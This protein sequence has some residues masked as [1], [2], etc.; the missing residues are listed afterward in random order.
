M[1]PHVRFGVSK[2]IVTRVDYVLYAGNRTGVSE[3]EQVMLANVEKGCTKEYRDDLPSI[4]S[5]AKPTLCKLNFQLT[6]ISGIIVNVYMYIILTTIDSY[7]F[8]DKALILQGIAMCLP[9]TTAGLF[10][11]FQK[12]LTA[13]F[14]LP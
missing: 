1:P 6:K 12:V 7:A 10:L 8:T 4:W 5:D 2:H 13:C 11:I 3:I 14:Q 9:V